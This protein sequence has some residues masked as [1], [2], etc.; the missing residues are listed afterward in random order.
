MAFI[1][2]TSPTA[3]TTAAGNERGQSRDISGLLRQLTD[4]DAAVRRWAARDL[5]PFAEATATLVERLQSEHDVSVREIIL[6]TL[7]RQGGAV[8]VAG[9]VGCLRSEDALLRN[10][11]IEAM[12][13]L[14]AE[15]A[16][17]M[18]AL[19]HDADSDVR[20]MAVNILESLHHPMVEQWL[21][22]VIDHDSVVNVCGT[23]VDL[24]GELGS[25]QAE[26]A[27]QRLKSRFA[28]EPYIQFAANLALKRIAK[29]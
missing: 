12:K 19:L 9:L 22:E 16:P 27:L 11:A 20:I 13:V 1:R 28:D 4:P 14:P 23:A 5:L 17:I 26:G 21:I 10:E 29:A 3:T 2:T 6:T 25:A 18:G 24:L 15:M 8:A 7:T